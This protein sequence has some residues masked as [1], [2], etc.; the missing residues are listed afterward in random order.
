MDEEDLR[1]K[2]KSKPNRLAAIIQNAKRFT[3]PISKVELIEDMEYMP[4]SITTT[5]RMLERE[6]VCRAASATIKKVKLAK[7]KQEGNENEPK[8]HSLSTKAK[9]ALEK[10]KKS[11]LTITIDKAPITSRDRRGGRL[12]KRQVEDMQAANANFDNRCFTSVTAAWE[13]FRTEAAPQQL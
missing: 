4:K 1:E 3:R 7:P 9:E 2:C 5:K 13:G 11:P 8:L 10:H 6:S 12:K